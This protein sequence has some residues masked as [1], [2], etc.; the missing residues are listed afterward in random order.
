MRHEHDGRSRGVLLKAAM[1]S[2]TAR[3]PVGFNAEVAQFSCHAV[4]A[5]PETSIQH[6]PSSYSGAERV[7]GHMVRIAACAQPF[8]SHGGGVGVVL[9]NH[10]YPEPALDVI[11]HREVRPAWKVGRFHDGA[12]IHVDKA[13]HPNADSRQ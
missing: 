4:H 9:Q 10:G 6:Q 3:M 5:M 2:T 11:S 1:A 12:S 8:F 13:G 7:H